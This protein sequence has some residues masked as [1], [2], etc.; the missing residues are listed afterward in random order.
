MNSSDF[1]ENDH[2]KPAPEGGELNRPNNAPIQATRLKVEKQ[3]DGLV[4][5]T[6]HSGPLDS[7][8]FLLPA[9][10]TSDLQVAL[11]HITNL[12]THQSDTR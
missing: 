2:M 8:S 4:R 9:E 1:L 11:T 5:M 12:P 10:L 7:Y 6:V 3:I